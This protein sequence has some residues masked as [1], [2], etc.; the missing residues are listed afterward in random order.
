MVHELTAIRGYT[1]RCKALEEQG[2]RPVAVHGLSHKNMLNA[3]ATDVLIA[4][5]AVDMIERKVRMQ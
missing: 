2:S 1:R 4:V 5:A 3:A